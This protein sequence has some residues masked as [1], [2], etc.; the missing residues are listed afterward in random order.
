MNSFGT[1]FRFTSFGESHGE[2]FGVVVDGCPAG[3]ELDLEAISLELARRKPGQSKHVTPR[4]EDDEFEILSGLFEGK[5]TGT[6]I[7]AIVRNTDVK[8]KDYS[9]IKE[10]FRPGHADFTYQFKYGLRDYRGG[11]RSSARETIARVIAG[12]IAKQVLKS[13]VPGLLIRAGVTQVGSV[14][15]SKYDWGK[16]RE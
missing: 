13:E 12:A 16:C 5:T 14:K 2:G 7:A 4:K 11:G 1:L 3:V 8:S 6:P 15:T 10:L 9:N